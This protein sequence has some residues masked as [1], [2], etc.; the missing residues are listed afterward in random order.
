M[1]ECIV[2]LLLFLPK[3]L[4][5]TM[6]QLLSLSLHY[7]KL[8]KT[9]NNTLVIVDHMSHSIVGIPCCKGSFQG[10]SKAWSA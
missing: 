10:K 5:V 3:P 2:R 9:F 1:V 6:L 8:L 4:E 7:Q